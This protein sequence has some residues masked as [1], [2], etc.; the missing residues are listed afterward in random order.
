MNQLIN[1]ILQSFLENTDS[2]HTFKLTKNVKINLQVKLRDWSYDLNKVRILISMI[3]K[4][5][6]SIS[7]I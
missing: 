7:V 6:I 5:K 3:T 1:F 2:F 4:V